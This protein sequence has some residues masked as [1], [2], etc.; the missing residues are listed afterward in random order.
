MILYNVDS[1]IGNNK[2]PTVAQCYKTKAGAINAFNKR[3]VGGVYDRIVL[4]K[5]DTENKDH[6]MVLMEV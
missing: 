4:W 5:E 1:Y 2:Y 3:N 6:R